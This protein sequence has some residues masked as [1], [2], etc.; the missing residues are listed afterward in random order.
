MIRWAAISLFD[1]WLVHL[2]RSTFD[3]AKAFCPAV[4]LVNAEHVRGMYIALEA[5]N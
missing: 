3:S 4:T 1:L 5:S 2:T